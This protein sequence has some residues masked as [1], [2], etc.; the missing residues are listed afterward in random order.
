M[1]EDNVIPLWDEDIVDTR[2]RA[3]KEAPPVPLEERLLGAID[4]A[5]IE[6]EPD[7]PIVRNLICKRGVTIFAGAAGN[8]KTYCCQMLAAACA[9]GG[10]WFGEKVRQC[11]SLTIFSEDWATMLKPRQERIC[12][13]YGITTLDLSGWVTYMPDDG[14]DFEIFA[15]FR[16]GSKGNPRTM[17]DQVIVECNARSASGEPFELLILD[18][19]QT[20][21]TVDPNNDIETKSALR[22]MN[23]QARILDCA[24]IL[25]MNPPKYPLREGM[26]TYYRGSVEIHNTP[27]YALSLNAARE[28]KKAI[29]NR[30][31]LK[32]EKN[33]YL[34]NDH[35]FKDPGI[36]LEWRDEVLQLRAAEIARWAAE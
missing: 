7:D 17:W 4:L 28:G 21:F 27:R 9:T 19:F 20:L 10:E 25:I 29:K 33:S 13:H 2:R 24:I 23:A 15:C 18:N 12:R 32:V 30:F 36:E 16:K 26:E 14:G 1:A 6:D 3:K 11:R 5:D 22:F 31:I 8:G 34:R 35:R